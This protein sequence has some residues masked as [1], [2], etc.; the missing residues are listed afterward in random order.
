MKKRLILL[1]MLGGLLLSGCQ[2]TIFGKTIK[3]FEKDNKSEKG[4]NEGSNNNQGGNESGSH[5][6]GGMVGND[7]TLDFTDSY[8]KDEKVTPFVEDNTTL[9]TFEFDGITYNDKGSF[10][11]QYTPD[12]GDTIR[13]LMMK[14]KWEDGKVVEGEEFAFIGNATA[15][16][17]AIKSIDVE[18]SSQTGG[19]DFV[20]A[21][22]S[23]AFTTSSTSGAKKYT[24]AASKSATFSA[25]C[26]DS[27]QFF[28]ISATTAVGQYRKNGGIAKIVVHF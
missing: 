18:V 24:A 2:F 13:W 20:V 3:L 5:G 1:P 25:T 23:S 12:N 14:N 10:A 19:V 17:K 7:L 16:G 4:S 15:Y 22:G 21:F 11:N 8:W 26:S 28:S 9:Q 27:S 6:G